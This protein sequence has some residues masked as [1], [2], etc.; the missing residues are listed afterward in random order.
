MRKYSEETKKKLI[1]MRCNKCG[2]LIS[3]DNGIINQGVF[4]VTYGWGYF[5]EKDGQVH[6]FDLCEECYDE[7]TK[8]FLIPI[9]VE[10]RNEIV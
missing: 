1:G 8:T 6:E 9:D 3:V 5:S 7:Y 2:K 10:E 4:T